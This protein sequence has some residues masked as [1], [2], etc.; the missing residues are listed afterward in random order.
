MTI[1]EATLGAAVAAG[2]A[3]LASHALHRGAWRGPTELLARLHAALLLASL[4][5]LVVAFLATDLGYAYVWDH[6]QEGYPVWYRLSGVWGG[7]EGTVLLWAAFAGALLLAVLRRGDADGGVHRRAALLLAGFTTALAIVPLA[8]GG[9]GATPADR[10]ALAPQ[11]RGL[12]DVLLTPLMVIHPPVQ[13]VAY[14]LL[15]PVGAY[16]V[17][18]WLRPAADRETAWLRPAYAWA[19]WAW[20]FGTL[21]LGLG[22]IW[23]YYVL[24]FGGYWAWDPVETANLLPWLAL[25]GFLHA[26]KVALRHG[27]QPLAAPLFG[28]GAFALTLFA[29]F[30]TRSGLWVS[31]HAFTDPT[32]RFEPDAAL[33]L[34]GIVDVHL[35]TRLFLA[36]LGA[37]VAGGLALFL[38]HHA[39]RL[40]RPVRAYLRAHAVALLA[41]GG[42]GLADPGA[43]WAL[44]FRAASLAPSMTLGLG[45]V[46]GVLL[47]LP[48][49]ALY[50]AR[51]DASGPPRALDARTLLGAAVALFALAAAVTFLLNL[52]VVNRPDRLLFDRRAPFLALPLALVLA[53]T[54]ALAPLGRRGALLLAG[55]GLALGLAGLALAP[56]HR[57]LALSAPILAA[58]ALAALLRLRHAMGRGAPARL[59]LAGTLL[60]AAA[61][62]GLAFWSNPP[63]RLL[64]RDL[65]QGPSFALGVAGFLLS[66]LALAGALAALRGK[67]PG[68]ALAGAAAGTLAAGYALGAPLGLAA[69]VL[70]LRDRRALGPLALRSEAARVRE[71]GTWLLHLAVVLGL[72]GYAASTYSQQATTYTAVALDHAGEVGDYHLHLGDARATTD[73][74]G[75]LARLD[76]PVHLARGG[77]DAGAGTLSFSWERDHYKG[78]LDVQRHLLA[79]VYLTP[80]A[81]HTPEGWV[82]ADAAGTTPPGTTQVDAITYRAAVLPLVTLL[83]AGL[84]LGLLGMTMVLAGAALGGDPPAE[85]RSKDA[86]RVPVEGPPQPTR[87]E[88][89]GGLR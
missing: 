32:D 24:S 35:P 2:A 28:F 89:P 71:A 68:L 61:L 79:D 46:A 88:T 73:A 5:L 78:H 3:A 19:R 11:G 37:V 65:A 66:A 47:G 33:R 70:L 26:G 23:A 7:E 48:L 21:G 12:A 20:L 77:R 27:D 59:R 29:T 31:V 84:W 49:A 30:A 41:W 82:G 44:L 76:V 16:V 74:Q 51:E 53:V 55:G 64:G 6:T 63:T 72:L 67:G 22:A 83:W 38:L 50:L 62:L 13:F 86:R 1:L 36:L 15:A 34:L 60:L 10:L 42:M 4:S 45:H 75:R 80:L 9:F 58:A 25:T 54:L 17:A 56:D 69:L 52:Q 40:P 57:V 87:P 43:A 14:A 81:F 39:P 8:S 85:A 18:A